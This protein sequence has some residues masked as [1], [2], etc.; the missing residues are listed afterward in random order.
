MRSDKGSTTAATTP[1]VDR[2]AGREQPAHRPREPVLCA[3]CGAVSVRSRW[4]RSANARRRVAAA[5]LP[6]DVRFCPACRRRESGLPRGFVHVD[7]DFVGPHRDSIVRLLHDEAARA[8]E[9]NPL[10]RVLDWGDDG[11]GGMIVTTTTEHL[12]IRL[13]RALEKAFEGKVLYGFSHQNTLAHVWWH[14]DQAA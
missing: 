8:A 6:I 9:D 13:G 2:D 4:S 7:G 3:G 12:A 11:T 14:R 1:S 5:G 10:A